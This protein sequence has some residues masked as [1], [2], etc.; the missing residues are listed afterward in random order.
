MTSVKSIV[1]RA[2][3][4]YFEEWR[5]REKICPA[6][7][8]KVHVTRLGWNH[9][10]YLPR[11]RL[12]DKIIRLKNLNIAKE[13]LETAT[14]YQTIEKKGAYYRYGLWAI[15]GN[16]RFKVVVSSKG[17][18]GRKTFFSFMVSSLTRK[19]QLKTIRQNKKI[20]REFRKRNPRRKRKK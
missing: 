4:F 6:F 20:I 11:R 15:R 13:I 8:E 17:K 14:T 5:G 12:V 3:K 9:I 18:K 10:V 19:E 1:N 16:K 7:G 2:K